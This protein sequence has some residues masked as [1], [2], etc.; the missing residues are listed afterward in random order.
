MSLGNCCFVTLK[1]YFLFLYIYLFIYLLYISISGPL[2]SQSSHAQRP[3]SQPFSPFFSEKGQPNPVYYS[4]PAHQVTRG[5]EHSLPL[6][7]CKAN[8]LEEHIPQ[9]SKNFQ[10]SPCSTCSEPTKRPSCTSATQ[11]WEVQVQAILTLWLMVQSVRVHI[12]LGSINASQN[13][14][15]R[16]LKPHLIL[17]YGFQHLFPSA[18]GQSC[19]KDSYA[20]NPICEHSRV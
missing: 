17:G 11:V 15:T 19:P 5:Q 7:P 9:I 18:T 6:R 1:F 13:S 10:G 14:C 4:T 12:H 2:S 20:R 8:Q 3:S 16:F